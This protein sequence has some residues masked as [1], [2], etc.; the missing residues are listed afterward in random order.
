MFE[1]QHLLLLRAIWWSKFESKFKCCSFFSTTVLIRHLWQLKSVFSCIGV[2]YLLFYCSE[3][4]IIYKFVN[5]S[6][7]I[8]SV[9]PL[10]WPVTN[11]IELFSALYLFMLLLAYCLRF[12]L[13]LHCKEHKLCRKKFHDIG[14][15]SDNFCQLLLLKALYDFLEIWRSPKSYDIF[16]LLIALTN[17]YIFTERSSFKTWFFAHL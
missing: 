7:L 14:H 4:N 16:G 8:M 2:K 12:L 6:L 3:Q 1:Y 15:W 9:V 17:F 11:C 10:M 13:W 5:S